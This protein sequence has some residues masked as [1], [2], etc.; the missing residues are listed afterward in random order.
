MADD[1]DTAA[2]DLVLGF[3]TWWGSW[4]LPSGIAEVATD[5]AIVVA[6]AGLVV[7]V[8]PPAIAI[9]CCY[10]DTYIHTS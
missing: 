10:I 6:A 7:A 2:L 9:A 8:A 1:A 3:A 4:F 5:D